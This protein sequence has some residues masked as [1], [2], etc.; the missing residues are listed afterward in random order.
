MPTDAL[1]DPIGLICEDPMWRIDYVTAR[2]DLEVTP[3]P[4]VRAAGDRYKEATVVL[5]RVA[6]RDELDRDAAEVA[7]NPHLVVIALVDD[8]TIEMMRAAMN[9]GV[10]AVLSADA[11]EEELARAVV[12]AEERVRALELHHIVGD[13]VKPT[14]GWLVIVTSAKGGQGASTVATNLALALHADPV[15]RVILV[16]GDMRFGD[17]G[18][19]LGFVANKQNPFV[20]AAL[21]RAPEWFQ[22]YLWRHQP[23]G[24]VTAMP[25]RAARGADELPAD[26]V[27]R[28]LGTAQTLSEI[29][30]VDMPFAVLEQTRIDTWA[31][32]ILLVTGDAPRDLANAA[33]AARVF[34]ENCA[35]SGLVI[36][37]YVDGRTPKRRTLHK[38]TG[39]EV[40][41][42]IPEYEDARSHDAAGRPSVLEDPA[43]PV[44]QAYGELAA[45]LLEQLTASA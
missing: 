3:L 6:S 29:V 8:V 12:D 37:G 13:A 33:L 15:R 19:L 44:A 42:R 40:F 18:S 27:M 45:R 22:P 30:V 14:A 26:V 34:R 32:S 23:S 11:S 5:W 43:G 41:G 1:G 7:A 31:D 38:D 17:L 21:A 35:G 4:N 36:A 10:F 39:L 24:L 9:A 20:P 28:A 16:D 25:P 2:R